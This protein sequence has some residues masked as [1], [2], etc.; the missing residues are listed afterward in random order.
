MGQEIQVGTYQDEEDS[1][2]S[3]LCGATDAGQTPDGWSGRNEMRGFGE[4]M[5][6]ERVRAFSWQGLL[7]QCNAIRLRTPT[8]D[9]S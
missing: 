7:V 2:Q 8:M 3:P 6:G 4:W 9:L 5:T 1:V